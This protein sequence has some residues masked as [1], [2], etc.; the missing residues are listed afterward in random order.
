V[1]VEYAQLVAQLSARLSA[2]I[3]AVEAA[4]W[5][6]VVARQS[7]SS[8]VWLRL[9]GDVAPLPE[10]TVVIDTGQTRTF[11]ALVED[12]AAGR[13]GVDNAATSTAVLVRGRALDASDGGGP[14]LRVAD[15]PTVEAGNSTDPGLGAVLAG[16]FM[17]ALR[18][19]AVDPEQAVT[20]LNIVP[21]DE[22]VLIGQW[23]DTQREY[24]LDATFIDLFRRQVDRTPKRVAVTATEGSFTYAELLA[25]A[26]DLASQ[27]REAGVD[28]DGIVCLLVDRGLEASVSMTGTLAANAAFVA[29]DPR[30]PPARLAY[31]LAQSRPVAVIVADRYR[32]LLTNAIAL[33]D[34]APALVSTRHAPTT[35]GATTPTQLHP[36]GSSGGSPGDLAYGVTTSGT[37]GLPKVALVEQRGFVNHC[38]GMID[39]LGLTESDVLAQTAPLSFDIAVWQYLTPL[40]T[41]AAVAIV[42]DEVAANPV[43]LIRH[44]A[45]LGITI[46]Q[47]V[48]SLLRAVLDVQSG[49]DL[50]ATLRLII[51]TGEALP[52]GLAIDWL[53]EFPD[54]PLLNLYGPA[55]CSDD[56]TSFLVRT[57]PAADELTIPIGRPMPNITVH[58][59]DERLRPVP[60]GALG[61]ICLGGVGVGRGYCND[62]ERTAS[63]FVTLPGDPTTRVYRTG[64]LGRF[65]SNGLLEY[66]GRRDFQLKIRGLRIEAGEVETALDLHDAL[67]ASVVVGHGDG[68]ARLLVAYVVPI[69]VAPTVDALRAHLAARLPAYMIPSTFVFLDQLPLTPNGKVDRRALPS[70]PRLTGTLASVE[71]ARTV[72]ALTTTEQRLITLWR[73]TLRT[74]RLDV[75]DDFFESGGTSIM[76]AVLFWKM[77]RDLDVDLPLSTL[78]LAPTVR[79]LAERIDRQAEM[80]SPVLVPL[81]PNGTKTPLFLF[82]AQ[83]GETLG[84]RYLAEQLD[85]TR[86]V[87]GLDPTRVRGS[88]PPRATMDAMVDRYL[89]VIRERQPS[90]PYLLGGF[91]MG[92]MVA[93]AT[94]QRLQREGEDVRLVVLLQSDHPDYPVTLP[95]VSPSTARRAQLR[96]RVSFE[97]SALRHCERGG[98]WDHIR[99]K[100]LG[101]LWAA[102]TLPIERRLDARAAATGRT[103]AGSERLDIDR[104]RRSD[105]GVYDGYAFT[106]YAGTVLQIRAER[107]P[108]LIVPDATLG[109]GP[110]FAGPQFLESVPGE[111]LEFLSRQAP[112]IAAIVDRHLTR[113]D[114]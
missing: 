99:V 45:R 72:A 64:D 83:G 61:E 69:A 56:T 68:D 8:T 84:Y 24:P 62:P 31:V 67:N 65:R 7:S 88:T 50:P 51:A 12:L 96:Q 80:P 49:D 52:V 43:A 39:E 57:K 73:E 23:N 5:C 74:D 107:Q 114:P 92:G 13:F 54:R 25:Q 32:S 108:R 91:C 30:N 105:G 15:E 106:P 34:V 71:P 102:A 16:Q 1:Q 37:T 20:G 22:A 46:L 63:V 18:S 59:L 87:Y 85:P 6:A 27:L 42:P 21:H 29:L 3:P 47:S 101:K 78:L 76:A 9:L 28:R 38:Y 53:D 40:L 93:W 81:Q 89:R 4:A 82:H 109:W 90:G 77:S 35:I 95:D 110:L 86:P 112:A 113:V 103:Y 36:G 100:V 14:T 66:G 17:Q 97:V 94:A 33:A 41:G 104:W 48:P 70:P 2:P 44:V 79:R 75:D 111:H 10:T 60:I 98:R 26:D 55:E 58:V 19:A 11:A